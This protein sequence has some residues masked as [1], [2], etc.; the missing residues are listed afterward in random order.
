M[1][2]HIHVY[3][4][5]Y[6]DIDI[7]THIYIRPILTPNGPKYGPMLPKPKPIATQ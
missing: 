6:I 7:Y 4:F 3:P 2:M 1:D 5:V